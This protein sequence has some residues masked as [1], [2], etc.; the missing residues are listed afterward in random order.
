MRYTSPYE[1]TV[2]LISPD[3]LLLVVVPPAFLFR[4]VLAVGLVP[5]V[6]SFEALRTAERHRPAAAT[7]RLPRDPPA[8]HPLN[9]CH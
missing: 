8:P 4:T 6:V 9:P 2:P 7:R 3:A 5:F 1:E